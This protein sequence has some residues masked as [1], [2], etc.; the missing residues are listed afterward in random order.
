M[1]FE[2]A[3]DNL[4]YLSLGII[5]NEQEGWNYA[6]T[7][8]NLQSGEMT[9][10]DNNISIAISNALEAEITTYATTLYNPMVSNE[11][12]DNE[13]NYHYFFGN[14]IFNINPLDMSAEIYFSD[15]ET[16][17]PPYPVFHLKDGQIAA[18]KQKPGGDINELLVIGDDNMSNKIYTLPFKMK[19]GEGWIHYLAHIA[20]AGD[21]QILVSGYEFNEGEENLLSTYLLALDD[22]SLTLVANGSNLYDFFEIPGYIIYSNYN[23]DSS[24]HSI[25]FISL[26]G[27]KIHTLTPGNELQFQDFIYNSL[28]NTFYIKQYSE[29]TGTYSIIIMDAATFELTNTAVTFSDDIWL[30]GVNPEGRLIIMDKP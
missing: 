14:S 26:D 27:T 6:K 16:S 23:P 3:S 21:N 2:D 28:N 4:E 1:I 9:P 5:T 17:R 29:S 22:G 30:I 19:T 20:D 13:N 15:Y 11:F 24:N 8:Y 7:I 25:D 18:I 12:W 10:L